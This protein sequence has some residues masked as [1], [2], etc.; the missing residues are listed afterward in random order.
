[1]VFH[2]RRE[3]RE[4]RI[5]FVTA[6]FTYGISDGAKWVLSLFFHKEHVWHQT[7]YV[8]VSDPKLLIN[9]I[10]H[11]QGLK[12]YVAIKRVET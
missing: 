4:T 11:C 9:T 10:S 6:D 1:M 8:G 5:Y 3:Q 7:H 12:P 2:S